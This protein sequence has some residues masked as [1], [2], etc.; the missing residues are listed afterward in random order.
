M[1]GKIKKWRRPRF[2]VVEIGSTPPTPPSTEAMVA[3][4]LTS[5]LVL[6]FSMWHVRSSSASVARR[7]AGCDVDSNENIVVLK[8]KTIWA[9]ERL[10]RLEH[11]WFIHLK[12]LAHFRSDSIGRFSAT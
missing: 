10:S 9:R 8:R 7:E 6:L 1:H 4:F 11:D 2:S 5:L 12:Q 3:A